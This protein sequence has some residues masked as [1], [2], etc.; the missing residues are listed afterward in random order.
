MNIN[1]EGSEI[2]KNDRGLR[3]CIHEVADECVDYTVNMEHVGMLYTVDTRL[4]PHEGVQ[5][6]SDGDGVFIFG[7]R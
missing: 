7:A 3:H 5:L 1:L 4:A 2:D 6:E